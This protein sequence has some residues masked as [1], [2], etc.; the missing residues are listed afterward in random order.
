MAGHSADTAPSLVCSQR[1]R[2]RDTATLRQLAA[3]RRPSGAL[4]YERDD[5]AIIARDA[6]S[7]CLLP[8]LAALKKFLSYFIFQAVKALKNISDPI[9]RRRWKNLRNS[10]RNDQNNGLVRGAGSDEC[11]MDPEGAS[12]NQLL[13]SR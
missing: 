9:L 3:R 8:S 2:H 12:I 13:I 11:G 7:T 1:R 4:C 6:L 5:E 10:L